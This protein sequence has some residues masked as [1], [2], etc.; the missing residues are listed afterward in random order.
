MHPNEYQ[1]EACRTFKDHKELTTKQAE[2]LDW[3]LGLAGEAGE[4]CELLKHHIF[5]EEQLDKMK[6]AKE[7]GDVLWYISAIAKTNRINMDTIL[8]LNISKLRHRYNNKTFNTTDSAS[9][10]TKEKCFEN[11]ELYQVLKKAIMEGEESDDC[12]Q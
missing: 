2:L 6:L 10:H 5:H 9:R 1:K 11:T 7:L 4:V 12:S 8:A 3:A